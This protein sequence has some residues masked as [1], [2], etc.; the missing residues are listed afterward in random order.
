MGTKKRH[1]CSLVVWDIARRHIDTVRKGKQN[2]QEIEDILVM[3]RSTLVTYSPNHFILF[4]CCVSQKFG[5]GSAGG[6]SFLLSG[7]DFQVDDRLV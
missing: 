6:L 4:H 3:N 1:V 5:L 2:T 7:G